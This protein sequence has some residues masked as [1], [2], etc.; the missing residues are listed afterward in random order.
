MVSVPSSTTMRG[1]MDTF[2][3]HLAPSGGSVQLQRKDKRTGDT[4]LADSEAHLDQ[5]DFELRMARTA[6]MLS[7]LGPSDK[8]LWAVGRKNDGN[9]CYT[10]RDFKG[11][12][13]C[14]LDALVGL[15]FG[16]SEEE[17]AKAVHA[18]QIPVLCNLAACYVHERLWKKVVTLCEEAL[19]LDP[20]CAKALARRG[21]AFTALH[22]F[23]EARADLRR[24]TELHPDFGDRYL[25]RLKGEE[26]RVKQQRCDEREMARK[27]V[28]S[29]EHSIYEDKPLLEGEGGG[30]G[31]GAAAA[32]Q[33]VR[34]WQYITAALALCLQWW[35]QPKY[36]FC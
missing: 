3:R 4:Y 7:A 18:V 25:R 20:R 9:G 8:L 13:Q 27:M 29:S 32:V 34:W 28:A 10:R 15:D 1:M 12:Q 6:K 26:L 31:S 5:A 24:A 36:K 19:K 35:K 17:K 33:T 21:Q 2:N 30:S 14:Y 22:R 23:A 16:E 11:A